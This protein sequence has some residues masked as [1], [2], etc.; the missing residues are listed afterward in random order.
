MSMSEDTPPPPEPLPD[1]ELQERVERLRLL[2]ERVKARRDLWASW[3][4]EMR[5]IRQEQA[6]RRGQQ[7]Q[8][9]GLLPP[10]QE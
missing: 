9:A 3:D 7:I 1:T 6:W 8:R 10:R 4:L 5:I 2:S